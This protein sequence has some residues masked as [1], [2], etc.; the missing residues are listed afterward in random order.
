MTLRISFLRT[1]DDFLT[2]AEDAA[3]HYKLEITEANFYVCKMVFNE[4][5]VTAIER[6]LTKSPTMCCYIEVVAKTFLATTSQLSWSH[7]DVFTTSSDSHE[8]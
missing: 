8:H 3:K 1:K 2:I 4:N 7:Q 5:V 6:T